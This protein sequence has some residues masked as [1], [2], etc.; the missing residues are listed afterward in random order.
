MLRGPSKGT[1][2]DVVIPLRIVIAAPAERI[3]RYLVDWERL[4]RWMHEASD[5]EVVSAQREGVGV[6]A[7]A[8]VRLAGFRTRDRIRV[9]RWEPPSI[10]EIAHLGWVRGEGYMELSPTEDGTELFWRE[11]LIPPWGVI[12]WIGLRIFKP[13]MRR[14]FAGDLRS[15]KRLVEGEL[16]TEGSGGT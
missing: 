14:Q 10:L 2:R 15:L 3:W 5:F 12:G 1:T 9:T 4:D 16:R 11:R 7:E 6:E 13:L 8:T